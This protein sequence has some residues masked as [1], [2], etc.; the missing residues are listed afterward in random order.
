MKKQPLPHRAIRMARTRN[1]DN[2][3]ADKDVEPRNSLWLLAEI[4]RGAGTSESRQ[5][6]AK[7]NKHLPYNPAIILL[8]IY[9]KELKTFV[10]TKTCT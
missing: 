8:G 3:N 9:P 6:L 5:V 7:L 1:T 10:H 4:Q 2:P